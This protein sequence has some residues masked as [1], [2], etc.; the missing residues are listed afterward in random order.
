MCSA[1]VSQQEQVRLTA[2]DMRDMHI[3]VRSQLALRVKARKALGDRRRFVS[4]PCSFF[5]MSRHA[6]LLAGFVSHEPFFHKLPVGSSAETS[7]FYET[8]EA[9]WVLEK[10]R[11][12]GRSSTEIARLLSF[13]ISSSHVEYSASFFLKAAYLPIPGLGIYSIECCFVLVGWWVGH[14]QIEN[15]SFKKMSIFMD[16]P[17]VLNCHYIF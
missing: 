5:K 8:I 14:E 10:R 4:L 13:T 12:C 15:V 7:G 17:L 6:T 16:G 1:G 2:P 11:T 9:M 3:W